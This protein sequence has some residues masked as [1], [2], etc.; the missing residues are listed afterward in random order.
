MSWLFWL[1]VL[2]L[3]AA[4]SGSAYMAYRTYVS[5]DTNVH[6]NGRDTGAAA[7]RRCSATGAVG[8][9]FSALR[10]FKSDIACS[11]LIHCGRF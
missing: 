11:L 4:A 6:M 10:R 5:G 3:L 9:A 1:F 7:G 8:L 2:V